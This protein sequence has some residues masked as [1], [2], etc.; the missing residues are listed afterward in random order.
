M[1]TANRR[2]ERRSDIVTWIKNNFKVSART[3][4]DGKYSCVICRWPVSLTFQSM[5]RLGNTLKVHTSR[6]PYRNYHIGT[7]CCYLMYTLKCGEYFECVVN[8]SVR[9]APAK[10]KPCLF[11]HCPNCNLTPL[12]RKSGHFV[13]QIF[14]RKWEN[15]LNNNFDFG[16][17]YFDSD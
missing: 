14:C 11:G 16:N 4:E 12:M 7:L 6:L 13:A 10:K 2:L 8:V 17:E 3:R 15:S 1:A 5:R 9:E